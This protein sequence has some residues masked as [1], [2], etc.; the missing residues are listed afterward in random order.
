ML[1]RDQHTTVFVTII[2]DLLFCISENF[3][4]YHNIGCPK[5][6]KTD[7]YSNCSG[8]RQQSLMPLKTAL[9]LKP[10]QLYFD[11][12]YYSQ[13]AKTTEFSKHRA[14]N[15]N[16]I[17]AYFTFFYCFAWY[18]LKLSRIP[19]DVVDCYCILPSLN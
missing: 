6:D 2:S 8:S 15:K 13:G 7:K 4:M 9:F 16:F 19:I 10:H 17:S 11:C 5:S 18:W 14:W 1:S 12:N 3:L